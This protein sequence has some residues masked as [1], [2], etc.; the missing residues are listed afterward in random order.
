[1]EG[2]RIGDRIK[3]LRKQQGLTQ[4]KLAQ[5]AAGLS[6][7]AISQI[8]RGDADPNANTLHQIAK[9]LRVTTDFLLTGEKSIDREDAKEVVDKIKQLLVHVHGQ[10]L[11]IPLVGTLPHVKLPWRPEAVADWKELPPAWLDD[12]GGYLVHVGRRDNNARNGNRFDR[13]VGDR[14]GNQ[15][16]HDHECRGDP[17]FHFPTTR[18]SSASITLRPSAA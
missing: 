8:E 5:A 14:R 1:M 9:A 10:A 6:S 3:A 11:R 2:V 12:P 7:A 4:R 16:W 17:G 15:Q 13:P 18:S